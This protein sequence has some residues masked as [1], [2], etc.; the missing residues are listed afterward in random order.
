[1]SLKS[2][3]YSKK[4]LDH[5]RNPRNVGTL[6]GDDV[7]VGRVGNPICGDLMEIYIRVKDDRIEDIKFRTFGCGSAIATSSMITE[8]VQG[9]TLDEVDASIAQGCRGRTRRSAPIKDA[10][11]QLG[12]GRLTRGLSQSGEAKRPRRGKTR[13]L[14]CR[15]RN[16]GGK[17][18]PRQRIFRVCG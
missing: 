9:L 4:V 17:R 3:Q 5:F 10:L 11:L 8:M 14:T 12:S 6:E 2:T 18:I 1:M 15:H 16:R 7:A 13:S